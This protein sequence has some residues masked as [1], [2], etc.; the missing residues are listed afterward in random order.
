MRT[1]NATDAD[2]TATRR[3]TLDGRG[4]SVAASD[5]AGAI[6]TA[7]RHSVASQVDEA[8]VV[9]PDAPGGHEREDEERD[10]LV[11]L[12]PHEARA[13]EVDVLQ[14]ELLAETE[15]RRPAA[16]DAEDQRQAGSQLERRGAASRRLTVAQS[17]ACRQPDSRGRWR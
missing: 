16:G 7:S 8:V 17:V 3:R 15:E 11:R 13:R 5:P 14:E 2:G 6:R 10:P 4:G 1:S 9:A 12:L